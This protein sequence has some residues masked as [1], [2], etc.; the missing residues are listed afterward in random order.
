MNNQTDKIITNLNEAPEFFNYQRL[1][2]DYLE[3]T[4]KRDASLDE[5]Y[6]L[7]QNKERWVSN[8]YWYNR[9]KKD[10]QNIERYIS[11]QRINDNST[12]EKDIRNENSKEISTDI[13]KDKKGNLINLFPSKNINFKSASLHP[14][15]SA[16][17]DFYHSQSIIGEHTNQE[18]LIYALLACQNIGIE[19]LP[20]SGKSALLY[21]TLNALPTE[22]YHV[23]HQATAKSLYNNPNINNTSIWII[24]ELQKIFTPELEELIKNLTEGQTSTYTRTNQHKTGID[25]FTIEK[26]T[27][28]YTF[29]ITNSHLKHRDDEFYRRFTIL[30]TDISKE[31][32]RLI[33]SHAA[34]LELTSKTSYNQKPFQHHISTL[35]A[36]TTKIKNPY[37]TYLN[38]NFPEHILN[39]PQF[40]TIQHY[41][42]NIIKGCTLY[43]NTNYSS[44][45]LFSSLSDT[46]HTL[47]IYT[48]TLLANLYNLNIIDN[49]LL[50]LIPEQHSP[51]NLD[52]PP[53]TLNALKEQF[54]SSYTP[55]LPIED[56]IKKLTQANLLTIYPN[57]TFHRTISLTIAFNVDH[58]VETAAHNM[59]QHYPQYFEEWFAQ[60]THHKQ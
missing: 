4:R 5:G 56:S 3:K 27:I 18:L 14:T 21:A 55:H 12:S 39:R 45:L 31:K 11:E 46:L 29:A 50:H 52:Q 6:N 1:I 44:Q 53:I 60:Q 47:N 10:L 36:T 22:S 30:H 54:Y 35:L 37:R 48:S 19:S 15:P 26:K 49:T 43:H 9:I 17:H 13:N 51:Q 25:S 38:Q 57:Q 16:I 8:R 42:N 59:Q 33:A 34:Q 23:I 28:L 41:L 2:W 58:A 7:L 32:N 40:P 20:G 24:P